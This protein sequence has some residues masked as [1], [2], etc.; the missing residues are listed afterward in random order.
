M[1]LNTI[2][3]IGP[4][5]S[6]KGTQ[7]K[8]L[9]A[10]LGFFYWE[11][12]GILREVAA[13]NTTL[14]KEI[15]GLIENGVLLPDEKLW[16]VVT[17]RLER[18]SKNSGVIFDGIPRRINQAEWLLEYLKNQGREDFT[19]LFIDVPKE[20]SVKRILERSKKEG[21]ADDT[22]KLVEK[23]L[24]Q[25]YESTLPVVEYLKNNTNF[26]EIDGR[27]PVE[28]VTIEIASAIGVK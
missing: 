21:R 6:G 10:K 4:Q 1:N 24:K 9:A 5:G 22:E 14:G 2:F 19:T 26:F 8:K 20:E 28:D 3:F 16:E 12:G 15:K 18:I 13:E 11:M 17:M 7:A 25:Y 23:R 27:P